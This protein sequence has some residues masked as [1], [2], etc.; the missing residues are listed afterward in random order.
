[1]LVLCVNA[2]GT[3]TDNTVCVVSDKCTLA[4]LCV[5]VCVCVCL[6]VCVCVCL[7]VCV[8]VCLCEC[9]LFLKEV[10]S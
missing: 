6:C 1:M 3:K 2:I 4:C 8:C 9:L 10:L 5:C 7:C